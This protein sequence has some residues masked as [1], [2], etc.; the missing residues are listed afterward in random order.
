MVLK[1][2][3]G[4][5]LD[6]LDIILIVLAVIVVIFVILY[7]VGRKLQSKADTSQNMIAQNKMTTS[8]LV[9]DKKKM[10]ITE[11]NLPKMVV[12]QIPKF[13]KLRKMPLVKAKIGP[14]ISTLICDPSVF[15]TL[16]IKKLV[17]VE[18]A[19]LYIVGY[20]ETKGS[21]KDKDTNKDKDKQAKWKFW[22]KK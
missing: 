7:F 15:K 5:D 19:G 2:E 11:A 14:K 18:L 13:Y 22:K 1:N 20:K 4:I 3:G 9:I 21:N 12:D 6:L 10:K 8:I 16:P 17:R